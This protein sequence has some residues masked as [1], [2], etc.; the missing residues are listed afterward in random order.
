MHLNIQ[1]IMINYYQYIKMEAGTFRF[2]S[3]SAGSEDGLK[4]QDGE[5]RKERPPIPATPFF[6]SAPMRL[7]PALL[8]FA[9][10]GA[11]V[12]WALRP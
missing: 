12:L 2:R 5:T 9:G 3:G 1:N 10:L 11:A 6:W 7:F 4:P 8:L